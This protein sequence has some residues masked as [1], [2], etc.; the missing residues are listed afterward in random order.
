[1]RNRAR[2]R[3]DLDVRIEH[4]PAVRPVHEAN[5][6]RH[7]QVAATGLVQDAS[8]QSSPQHV[9]LGLAHGALE[10]QE[11]AVVEVR[12]VVHAVFVEDQRVSDRA[13]LDESVPVRG[14]P[15]EPRDLESHDDS[16]PAHPDFGDEPLEAAAAFGAGAGQAE[17]VVDHGDL[18]DGPSERDR[19][20]PK[21]ILA[22]RAL[23]VLEHLAEGGL[24]DVEVG[25]PLEVVRA[26]LLVRSVGAHRGP[27]GG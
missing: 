16:C 27:P 8:P 14:V 6:Q 24:A 21:V 26:H 1:M 2:T 17:V 19:A 18:L 3:L 20:L 5:G 25:G 11:E 15:G 12:R 9:Q 22:P 23:R 13:D 10:S 4:D 7:L